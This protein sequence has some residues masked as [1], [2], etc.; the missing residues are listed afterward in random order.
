VTARAGATQRQREAVRALQ[1]R[2]LQRLVWHAYRAVSFYR[3]RLAHHGVHPRDIRGL[4]DLG[5][6]PII[7]KAELRA[8]PLQAT[9]ARGIQPDALLTRRTSGSSGQPFAVRRTWTEERLLQMLRIR[10]RLQIGLRPS[11]R[12]VV[13]KEPPLD[14]KGRTHLGQLLQ[15][16]GLFHREVVSC[17]LPVEEM[18]RLVAHHRPDVVSGYPSALQQIASHLL[19]EGRVVVRPRL[20]STGGE[21]LSAAAR[22]TIEAAFAAPVYDFYANQELNLLASGCPR[23]GAL[24]VCE[25]GV[26]LEVVRDGRAV[27]EGE[28]GEVIA[29]GLRSFAM[30]FIRYRVGDLATRGAASCSCGQPCSTLSGIQGRSPQYLEL[31]DRRVHPFAITGPLL[32]DHSAWIDQHQLIQE[33]ASLVRLRV[34]PARAPGAEALRQLARLGQEAV[35]PQARFEIELVDRFRPGPG[36][37]FQ[38]YL[39]LN[40]TAAERLP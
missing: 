24:H 3:E 16:V 19:D 34:R 6:L 27:A 29:T 30:P 15:G 25:Q 17:L 8:A 14:G 20:V 39:S 37:K 10:A 26:I 40:T 18:A 32:T 1:S 11:D 5:A 38:P 31:P 36:G 7:D 35:G 28:S 2:R 13:V 12:R 4:D 33:S 9:L 21:P 22:S 23:G